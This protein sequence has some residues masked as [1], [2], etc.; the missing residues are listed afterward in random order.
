[1]LLRFCH[2]LNMYQKTLL[3]WLL[4]FRSKCTSGLD[5]C[6]MYCSKKKKQKSHNGKKKCFQEQSIIAKSFWQ[7]LEQRP[8]HMGISKVTS[9]FIFSSHEV[10]KILSFILDNF[11]YQCVVHIIFKIASNVEIVVEL[12]M[13][14]YFWLF[15][16]GKFNKN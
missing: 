14:I 7:I 12:W 15:G 3:Q 4:W 5:G 16:W 13:F 6:K 8:L 1:M 2:L 11:I 10:F 9:L